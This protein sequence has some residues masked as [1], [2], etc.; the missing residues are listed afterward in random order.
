MK[1]AEQ[2][3]KTDAAVPI[4]TKAAP[5]TT[6]AAQTKNIVDL[7]EAKIQTLLKAGQ[8]HLPSDYSAENAMKSA[9]LILQEVKDKEGAP[10]LTVCTRE[11]IANALL[12]MVVQGLN[13]MK[14]QGYFI[15]YGKNLVFQRSYMGAMAVAQMVNPEIEDWGYAAVYEG[16]EFE[17]KIENGQKTVTKHTQKISNVDKANIIAAYCMALD[18]KGLPI[19]TEI[20]T[21][22]Q[23][24]QAWM[25]SKMNPIDDKGNVKP[26]STH[27]KFA[28]D[29][30]LKTVIGKC[31]KI[32]INSSSDNALL[33]NLNKH[34]DISDA[35]VVQSEIAEKANTGPVLEIT[36]TAGQEVDGE[37]QEKAGP[38]CVCDDMA[39][40]K[41]KEWTCP[42]HGTY[43]SG[44]F[45][46]P[47]E[48]K[49]NF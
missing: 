36:E 12:D 27:G 7:V 9:Y 40:Q 16:D 18:G 28:E 6:L 33:L 8:L 37:V 46:K 34:A 38:V 44:K 26:G 25:Q 17:Y 32:I 2:E 45:T 24:H 39:A 47:S 13:P 3:K 10:A 5:T 49:P 15:V 29:M 1:T 4:T 42:V 31:C 19:K 20:M 11:S 22:D 43:Q 23:I 41:L 35:A 14:K 48:R 21:V 30:A